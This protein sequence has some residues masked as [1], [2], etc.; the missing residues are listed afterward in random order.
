MYWP[1]DIAKRHKLFCQQIYSMMIEFYWHLYYQK[2][3]MYYWILYS[4]FPSLNYNKIIMKSHKYSACNHNSLNNWVGI[5]E[6]ENNLT[7]FNICFDLNFIA[8]HWELYNC[9]NICIRKIY[10]FSTSQHYLK[11]KYFAYCIFN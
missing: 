9:G 3:N 6:D 11:Q 1:Q 7:I 2:T 8:L 4:P 10:Y 5:S